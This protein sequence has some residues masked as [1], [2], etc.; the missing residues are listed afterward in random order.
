MILDEVCGAL[1]P[2]RWSY[3]RRVAGV[4]SGAGEY[5]PA[6][7]LDRRPG[8]TG[9][10]PIALLGK[11]CCKVDATHGPVEVGDLLTIGYAG[12]CDAGR[13]PGSGVRAVIGKALGSF[14]QGRG[15]VPVLVALQ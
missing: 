6:L 9:R 4:V 14:A 12:P 3:D 2:C 13:R 7:V 11:V 15:L 1:R 10:V 8:Q 5:R